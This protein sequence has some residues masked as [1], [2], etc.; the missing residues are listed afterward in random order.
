MNELA[1][2]VPESAEVSVIFVGRVKDVVQKP[3]SCFVR[4]AENCSLLHDNSSEVMSTDD[5]VVF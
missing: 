1:R 5:T 3:L 2:K 4:V